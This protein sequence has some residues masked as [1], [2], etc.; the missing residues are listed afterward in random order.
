MEL[1]LSLSQLSAL[2]TVTLLTT[3][4]EAREKEWDIGELIAMINQYNPSPIG[5]H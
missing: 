5:V 4:Q 3:L 1:A 2:T